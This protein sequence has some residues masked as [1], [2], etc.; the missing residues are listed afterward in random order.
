[1]KQFLPIGCTPFD[2]DCTQV[3]PNVD[4]KPKMQKEC[5]VYKRQLSREFK[6]IGDMKFAVK[7]ET[8]DFGSYAEVVVYYND[9]SEEESHL[10]YTIEKYS[11]SHWDEEAKKELGLI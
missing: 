9:K 4:Y 10:A 5:D 1:M 3:N 2:E 7:W 6:L 8:S 11:S